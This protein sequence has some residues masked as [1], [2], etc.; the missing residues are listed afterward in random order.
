MHLPQFVSGDLY[1]HIEACVTTQNP[2]TAVCQQVLLAECRAKVSCRPRC[3]GGAE[4]ASSLEV[5]NGTR[6]ASDPAAAGDTP[7]PA[8][9]ERPSLRRR[10]RASK[11]KVSFGAGKERQQAAQCCTDR[12]Q[13]PAWR[14]SGLR[15]KKR[16]KSR[17]QA[18]NHDNC[19][20]L[21]FHRLPCS[22]SLQAQ[23]CMSGIAQARVGEHRILGCHTSAK[24]G[25]ERG[26]AAV[27]ALADTLKLHA[28]ARQQIGHKLAVRCPRLQLV[29]GETLQ[30][31]LHVLPEPRRHPAQG[32]SIYQALC[33]GHAATVIFTQR[34]GND[35]AATSASV[36]SELTAQNQPE[37]LVAKLPT[38][39]P[40]GRP[41]NF[42]PSI[43]R[44]VGERPKTGDPPLGGGEDPRMDPP[45][46]GGDPPRT[47]RSMEWDRSE[48]KESERCAVVCSSMLPYCRSLW[49]KPSRLMYSDV[50]FRSSA[51]I[52]MGFGIM[53]TVHVWSSARRKSP[54]TVST[55]EASRPERH[56]DVKASLIACV[57]APDTDTQ[58]PASLLPIQ[59]YI[60]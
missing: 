6:R 50:R 37:K 31:P 5:D 9:A 25:A 48:L 7:A 4:L 1:H 8:P 51:S 21:G 49:Q 27:G 52:C 45:R 28:S 19:G 22:E 42:H 32:H 35:C 3:S 59:A 43:S 54:T 23:R 13:A 41:G 57:F 44:G 24:A 16:R 39:V 46:G 18:L 10:C 40:A 12:A 58:P 53:P 29:G 55:A 38:L 15:G 2:S 33:L 30:S 56:V 34:L 47:A 17:Q 14:R 36:L 11:S 20:W 60:V 26:A